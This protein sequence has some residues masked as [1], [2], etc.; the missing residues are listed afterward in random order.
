MVRF[1]AFDSAKAMFDRLAEIKTKG[2][3]HMEE[4][5]LTAD[6]LGPGTYWVCL[7]EPDLL[8]IGRAEDSPYAS[9]NETIYRERANGYIYGRWFSTVV[10]E[11]EWGSNHV[12][13]CEEL[14]P[15]AFDVLM[16]W[17]QKEVS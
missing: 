6:D 1:E 10:P 9:D 17:I 3:A 13:W 12:S 2:R 4:R 14:T 11:G 7:S 8:I 16:S 15:E 5:G